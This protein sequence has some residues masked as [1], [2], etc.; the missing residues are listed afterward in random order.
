LSARRQVPTIRVSSAKA[1][2]ALIF[3]CDVWGAATFGCADAWLVTSAVTMT[4]MKNNIY[5]PGSILWVRQTLATL[6]KGLELQ[7]QQT[8]PGR[9][10]CLRA[11]AHTIHI[12]ESNRDELDRI[13]GINSIGIRAAMRSQSHP[14]IL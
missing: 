7:Y 12:A 8:W 10:A 9:S 6:F 5:P 13:D 4:A 1:S 3:S 14:S 2:S 11:V